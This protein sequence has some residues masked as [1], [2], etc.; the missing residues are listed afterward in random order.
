M[1]R[2][3]PNRLSLIFDEG[4][5]D[6]CFIIYTRSAFADFSILFIFL[7][8]RPIIFQKYVF[9]TILNFIN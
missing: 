7:F 2:V 4:E 8:S 3:L 9:L 1:R 5:W 6:N